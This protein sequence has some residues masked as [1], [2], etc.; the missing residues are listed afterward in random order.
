MGFAPAVQPAR[1]ALPAKAVFQQSYAA[2]FV[3]IQNVAPFRE[4][5]VAGPAVEG[6]A[7][8]LD[9]GLRKPGQAICERERAGAGQKP[10]P[11]R[12]RRPDFLSEL[13]FN[14]GLEYREILSAFSE[15]FEI[16]R[17]IGPVDGNIAE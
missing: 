8:K 15:I 9:V 1:Q 17:R 4:P 12:R 7:D 10:A 16:F 6:K 14:A 5:G 11:P 2:R 3:Q 13:L